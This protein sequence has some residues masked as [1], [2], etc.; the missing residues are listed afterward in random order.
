MLFHKASGTSTTRPHKSLNHTLTARKG[1]IMNTLKITA[2]ELAALINI[3][4]T[5]YSM[6]GTGTEFDDVVKK[7]VKVF[8]KMIARNATTIDALNSL[9]T[10]SA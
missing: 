7:D 3:R 6:V 5:L 1:E 10:E 8:D 4:D 9:N 2:L